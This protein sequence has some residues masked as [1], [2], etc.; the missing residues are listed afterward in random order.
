MKYWTAGKSQV[1]PI[2][3][4]NM[5]EHDNAAKFPCAKPCDEHLWEELER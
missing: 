5:L 3:D 4:M 1:F 2:Y